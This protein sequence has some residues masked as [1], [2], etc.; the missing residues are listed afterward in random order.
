M[1]HWIKAMAVTVMLWGASVTHSY[2][3]QV[4]IQPQDTT[5]SNT[6]S[7][8]PITVYPNPN[9]GKFMVSAPP[10]VIAEGTVLLSLYDLTGQQVQRAYLTPAHRTA[11]FDITSAPKGIY[12]LQ[13]RT[14]LH[15]YQVAVIVR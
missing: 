4:R 13:A 10:E 6:Q 7:N 8:T 5:Q 15:T 12:Y 3:L 1:G 14:S 11:Y 2:A 9:G